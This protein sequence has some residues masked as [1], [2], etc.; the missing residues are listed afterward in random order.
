MSLICRQTRMR[1]FEFRDRIHRPGQKHV[2]S[3]T[4]IHLR[5]GKS[6]GT[7]TAWFLFIMLC[8]L[9]NVYAI[10]ARSSSITRATSPEECKFSQP[11]EELFEKTQQRRAKIPIRNTERVTRLGEF[12]GGKTGVSDRLE[13]VLMLV[14][15]CVVYFLLRCYKNRRVENDK[16]S[17]QVRGK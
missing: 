2:I 7:R 9:A 12:K 3:V 1:Y 17:R 4:M 13:I 6:V 8:A 11:R 14:R 16:R 10:H 15:S 5:N